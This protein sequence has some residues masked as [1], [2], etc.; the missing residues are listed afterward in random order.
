MRKISILAM[1]FLLLALTIPAVWGGQDETALAQKYKLLENSVQK[2]QKYLDQ[3][4]LDKCDAEL[5]A[6][7]AAIPD[8]HAALHVKAQ[9]LYKEGNFQAALAAMDAAKAGFK[10][11]DEA[12]KRLQALK[13][14]KDMNSARAMADA[15][16]DLEARAAQ[17]KCKEGLY[18]GDV[19]V[20]QGRIN[21]KG[22]ELKQ[23]LI[24]AEE[25]SPAEYYYFAGNCQFKLKLY[26]D[27]EQSYRAALKAAPG[28]SSAATNLINLLFMQKKLDKARTVLAQAEANKAQVPPGL[29]KAV[30]EAK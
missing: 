5:A 11:L 19:M 22:E 29:K 26:T 8:H 28:H 16:P 14:D 25:T 6:C 27:A 2:A 9:R 12:I 13:L 17:T 7:F 10:R 15:E 23:G 3:G 24:T 21:Q 18:A 4:K 20:N 1:G 30:L